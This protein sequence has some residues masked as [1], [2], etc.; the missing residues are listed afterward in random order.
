MPDVSGRVGSDQVVADALGL[1][2][3]PEFI[4][5]KR[6]ELEAYDLTVHQWERD[7]YLETL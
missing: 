4:R 3:L 7:I 2:L 5:V 1:L 6:A